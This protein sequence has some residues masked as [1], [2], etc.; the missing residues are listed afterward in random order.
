MFVDT[1]PAMRAPVG[2]E[3]QILFDPGAFPV[4][5][6]FVKP[7]GLRNPNGLRTIVPRDKPQQRRLEHHRE[8]ALEWNQ[9]IHSPEHK[10]SRKG[11][12][13]EPAGQIFF[14]EPSLETPSSGGVTFAREF[15]VAPPRRVVT[16]ALR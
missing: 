1:V 6:R 15:P 9:P 10:T 13:S 8:L 3:Q 12:Q 7:S 11:K 14:S 16:D 5:P 4:T 2:V